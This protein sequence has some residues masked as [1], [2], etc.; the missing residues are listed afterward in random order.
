MFLNY[1]RINLP[2]EILCNVIEVANLKANKLNEI[3]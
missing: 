1:K 2:I 3:R